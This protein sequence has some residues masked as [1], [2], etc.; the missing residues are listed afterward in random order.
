[1]KVQF[2]LDHTS[3]GGTAI[4]PRIMR[5]STRIWAAGVQYMAYGRRVPACRVS[6]DSAAVDIYHFISEEFHAALMHDQYVSLWFIREVPV[7]SR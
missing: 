1:M 5:I 7:N 4:I 2:A 6:M 3:V